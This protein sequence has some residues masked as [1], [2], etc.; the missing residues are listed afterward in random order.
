LPVIATDQVGAAEDFVEPEV[1]G[2]IVAA[3]SSHELRAALGAIAHGRRDDGRK[4][5]GARPK[6]FASFSIK[7]GADGFFRGCTLALE[8]RD[9]RTRERAVE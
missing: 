8:H 6:R 2:Y 5:A 7:L 1:N 3:G 4:R 9:A